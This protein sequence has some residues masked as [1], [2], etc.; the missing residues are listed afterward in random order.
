MGMVRFSRSIVCRAQCSPHTRGDG[1]P[2]RSA[3]KRDFGTYR[4]P[5]TRGDGPNHMLVHYMAVTG[6]SPHTRGDG[7]TRGSPTAGLWR[8]PHTRGDGPRFTSTPSAIV[9]VLPTRVGMVRRPGDHAHTI[10]SSPHTRGDGPPSTSL[11]R[12]IVLVLPTRV[13]MVRDSW[14]IGLLRFEFSPHAWGWSGAALDAHG[15]YVAFSPHAWGWSATSTGTSRAVESSPHTRGDGPPSLRATATHC[16][17]SPHTRGDGPAVRKLTVRMPAFSPHAWGWSVRAVSVQVAV[18]ES[19]SPHAWG[20]SDA[21]SADCD[22]LGFSPHA[23]GWS[24]HRRIVQIGPAR[25]PH[26][27]GD[28]PYF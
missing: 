9:H 25:S 10:P 26:T 2:C 24:V 6:C 19:F 7:P 5:H 16:H 23:W 8:S 21:L 4:S 28:G 22:R 1:P 14:H 20:W 17:G 11:D 3:L 18:D 15:D 27:R 12:P 13:G